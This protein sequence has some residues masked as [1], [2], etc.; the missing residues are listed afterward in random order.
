[1]SIIY[2]PTL[3][4]LS[5]FVAIIGSLTGLA[6]TFGYNARSVFFSPKSLMKGAIIIG[7]SI[8]SMH[9]IAMLAVKFSVAVNYNST[10]TLLLLFVGVFFTRVGL[11]IASTKRVGLSTIPAA[12]VVLGS[13]NA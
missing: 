3:V 4:M 12:G 2:D 5:V 1:M 8:L 6:F 7:G 9:F 11:S 10:E 13:R